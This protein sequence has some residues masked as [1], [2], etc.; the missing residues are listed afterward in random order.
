M[1]GIINSTGSKSGIIGSTELVEAVSQTEFDARILA[2]TTAAQGLGTGNSPTFAGLSVSDAVDSMGTAGKFLYTS[3]TG[4][5]SYIFTARG[6]ETGTGTEDIYVPGNTTVG[7]CFIWASVSG[8][9][10]A[11][12]LYSGNHPARYALRVVDLGSAT[13]SIGYNGTALTGDCGAA[14]EWAIFQITTKI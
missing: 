12:S 9:A 2:A 11:C 5:L 1:S 4:G 14:F 3:G 6:H 13:A 8:P 7:I 10:Q